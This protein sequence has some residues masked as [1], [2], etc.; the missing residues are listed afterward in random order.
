MPIKN[1]TTEIKTFF[2]SSILQNQLR[3]GRIRPTSVIV[4]KKK[5]KVKGSIFLKN[6]HFFFI[7]ERF[8]KS[9]YSINTIIKYGI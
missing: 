7:K 8:N 9:I 1:S 2:S 6:R 3:D 5:L 4:E